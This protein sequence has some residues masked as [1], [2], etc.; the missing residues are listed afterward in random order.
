MNIL[1]NGV[2]LAVYL[3]IIMALYIFTSQP[4]HDVTTALSDL[5]VASD[6]ETQDTFTFIDTI[7]AIIFV[8]LAGIPSLWFIFKVFE[9][10]PEWGY[11]Q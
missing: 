6:A 4:F 2:I 8:I 5:D 1:R 9:R 10:D 7:Y 11:Y 3:F